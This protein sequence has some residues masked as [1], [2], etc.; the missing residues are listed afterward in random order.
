MSAVEYR[1]WTGAPVIHP[2]T[3]TGA[4]FKIRWPKFIVSRTGNRALVCCSV[5][6]AEMLRRGALMM[7]KTPLGHERAAEKIADY[8]AVGCIAFGV[9]I[10]LCA[11]YGYF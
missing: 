2:V 1:D 4:L 8:L 10:G 6:V 3:L 7:F 9:L 5:D 11:C